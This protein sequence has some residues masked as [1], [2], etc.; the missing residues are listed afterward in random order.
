MNSS[1][2]AGSYQN[3]F[4]HRIEHVHSLV[5]ELQHVLV[6]R[7]D[8]DIEILAGSLRHRANH[9]VGFET[10]ILQHRNAHRFEQSA[11]EGDLLGQI[12]RHLCSIGFVLG[13]LLFAERLSGF[14]NGRDVFRLVRCP[15]FP[16]HVMEDEHGLGRNPRGGPHRRRAA[17]SASMIRAKDKP[18]AVDQEQ[19]GTTIGAFLGGG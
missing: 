3:V 17:A 18:V 9:V 5:N 2:A 13:I 7:H 8:Y 16:H 19:P 1:V 10:R 4:F 12:G 14:E 6:A 11:D 15:E